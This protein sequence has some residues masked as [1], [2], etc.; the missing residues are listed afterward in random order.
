MA[1]ILT[2]CTRVCPCWLVNARVPSHV[3]SYV[4]FRISAMNVFNVLTI[5]LCL[6]SRP[7]PSY[8]HNSE[9]DVLR[10]VGSRKFQPC[11]WTG[12]YY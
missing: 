9:V 8:M 3:C 12:R 7:Q 4:Q 1:W 11:H 2:F 5:L 10:F 6:N